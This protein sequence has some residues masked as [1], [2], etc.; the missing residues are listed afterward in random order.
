M[1]ISV[2]NFQFEHPPLNDWDIANTRSTPINQSINIEPCFFLHSGENT[3]CLYIL[4][5]YFFSDIHNIFFSLSLHRWKLSICISGHYLLFAS[6]SRPCQYFYSDSNYY[7]ICSSGILNDIITLHV[8][9]ISLFEVF[10]STWEFSPHLET[11]T[12]PMNGC[13]FWPLLFAYGHWAGGDS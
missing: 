7:G 6:I 3:I 2:N 8:L 9:F 4:Y 11:S 13:K 1:K 10:R 12:L 5:V